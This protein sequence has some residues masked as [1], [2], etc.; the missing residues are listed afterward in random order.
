MLCLRP[1]IATL[2]PDPL[3]SGSDAVCFAVLTPHNT[4][5]CATYGMDPVRASLGVNPQWT[6]TGLF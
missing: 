1:T 4:Y 2:D 3:T 6:P 5:S